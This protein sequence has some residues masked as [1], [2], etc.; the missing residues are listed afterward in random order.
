MNPVKNSDNPEMYITGNNV[1]FVLTRL[2]I[3]G[4][5]AHFS[6]I[7]INPYLFYVIFKQRKANK[8]LSIPG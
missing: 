1:L 6:G 4:C 3:S 2:A 7:M 8:K 5:S